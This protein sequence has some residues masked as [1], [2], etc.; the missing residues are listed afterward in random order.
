M[1]EN[2][3]SAELCTRTHS[4]VLHSFRADGDKAG[5]MLAVIRAR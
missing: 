5:R 4:D 2:I 1:P 3:H